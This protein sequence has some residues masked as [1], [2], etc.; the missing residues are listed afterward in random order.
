[1]ILRTICDDA[2]HRGA[3][4]FAALWRRARESEGYTLTE[5][6]VTMAILLIV[7]GGLTQLMVSGTKAQSDMTSRFEAQQNARLA[8]DKLRREMHCANDV[9]EMNN[10]TLATG[11]HSA[12]KIKLGSYCRTVG[13]V[14]WCRRP[15][16][17]GGTVI[18]LYRITPVAGTAIPVLTECPQPSP[19]EP[20]CPN[21]CV[22]SVSGVVL[23]MVRWAEY[24]VIESGM[25]VFS[26]TPPIAG[27]GLRTTIN[28]D[29]WINRGGRRYH[30]K[31]DIVLR[32]KAR[33]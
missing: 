32:N 10:A 16:T 15:T 19:P 14:V 28:V 11:L 9:T 26:F 30:L 5:L 23:R 25:D 17:A 6:L 4:R 27:S 12:V 33:A 18:G 21:S 29:I 3:G 7:V 24:L 20:P 1:M 31:D 22:A 13:D 2:R 8:L